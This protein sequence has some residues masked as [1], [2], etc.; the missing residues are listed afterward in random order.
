VL[1]LLQ[2]PQISFTPIL[3]TPFFLG[4]LLTTFP[5]FSQIPALEKRIYVTNFALL[6][7]GLLLFLIGSLWSSI[8]IYIGVFLVLGALV[9]TMTLFYQ[10]YK[11]SPMPEL[12]DQ[13]WIMVGFGSGIISGLLFFIGF[14]TDSEI[15]KTHRNLSLFDYYCTLCWAENDSIFLSCYDR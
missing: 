2:P 3:C 10:I 6:S 13:K 8:L 9:Y 15:G 4:F 5:R 12:H 11:A 1:L 14:L 7:S